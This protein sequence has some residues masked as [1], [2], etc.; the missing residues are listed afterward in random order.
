MLTTWW[1]KKTNRHNWPSKLKNFL[2]SSIVLPH[3]GSLIITVHGQLSIPWR[4]RDRTSEVKPQE[5]TRTEV[6][7]LKRVQGKAFPRGD[8]ERSLQPLNPLMHDGIARGS[9]NLMFSE[10]LPFDARCPILLSTKHSL[11]KLT[12]I[13]YYEKLG[14]GTGAEHLLCELCTRYWVHKGRRLVQCIGKACPACRRRSSELDFGGPYMTRQ[15][16]GKSRKK[17]YLCLF[18]C[19]TT[20]AVHIEMAHGLGTD[21]F[22]NAFVPMTSR[23]GTPSYIISDTGTNLV[24]AGKELRQFILDLN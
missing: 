19:L 21:S 17:R 20:R 16:R 1:N 14:N 13:S 18:T 22:I 24:D 12:I 15:G 3:S 8:R 9:G 11:T 10:E 4:A 7:L 2:T 6:F 5:L 23:R